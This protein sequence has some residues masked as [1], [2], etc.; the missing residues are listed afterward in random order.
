MTSTEWE[1]LKE[2][3]NEEF[4]KKD[5]TSAIALYSQALNSNSNE[6]TLWGNRSQCYKAIGKIKQAKIDL[7]RA[8]EINPKNVKNIKRL[9]NIH[10]MSGNFGEAEQLQQR[11]VNLE[12]RDLTHSR[13]LNRVRTLIKDW[14]TLK[15][16][17]EKENYTKCEEIGSK[18][19]AECSHCLELKKM[20]IHSLLNNVKLKEALNFITNLS[21]EDKMD[22][23]IQYYLI[24]T[25]YYDGEL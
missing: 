21:S 14:E 7:Q 5:Y 15:D 25:Y 22:D 4:R 12:P 18:M 1:R 2:K 19:L 24:L 11:C 23:E 6:E 3:G 8:L 9:A 10:T 16:N 13:D 17:F 20:Y